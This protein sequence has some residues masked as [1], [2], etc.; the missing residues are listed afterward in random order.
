MLSDFVSAK[1]DS[2]QSRKPNRDSRKRGQFVRAENDRFWR[3]RQRR[4]I[5]EIFI[6]AADAGHLHGSKECRS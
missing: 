2:G 3:G 6:L 1:I 5:R 4:L